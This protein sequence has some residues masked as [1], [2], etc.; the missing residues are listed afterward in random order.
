M[1]KLNS[2]QKLALRIVYLIDYEIATR[3]DPEENTYNQHEQILL[4]ELTNLSNEM[5]TAFIENIGR[6][7]AQKITEE[8]WKINRKIKDGEQKDL[9]SK[10][11]DLILI[12]I[13]WIMGQ[14]MKN[15]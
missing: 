9:T 13:G 1:S 4:D 11:A 2:W 7:N 6:E 3:M 12:T 10:D 5:Q 14:E 8:L 15:D